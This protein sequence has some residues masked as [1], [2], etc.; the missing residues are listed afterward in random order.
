MKKDRKILIFLMFFIGITAIFLL[1]FD[2]ISKS[3]SEIFL[4]RDFCQWSNSFLPALQFF[5][6]DKKMNSFF[7]GDLIYF[8]RTLSLYKQN[9]IFSDLAIYKSGNK[10]IGL[11]NNPYP[12]ERLNIKDEI[13]FSENISTLFIIENGLFLNP[14]SILKPSF[15]SSVSI[16]NVYY[17]NEEEVAVAFRQN[18][19]NN[20]IPILIYAYSTY[21]SGRFAFTSNVYELEIFLDN[22]L[23]YERKLDN[24][25]KKKMVELISTS[26]RP[27]FIKYI[28]SNIS[29]GEHVLKVVVYDFFGRSK[30]IQKKFNV[31]TY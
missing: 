23:V 11:T 9:N 31:K 21:I 10:Y 20:F 14:L 19:K 4:V 17:L 24:I 29:D 13:E 1:F 7:S 18:Y 12:S 15:S 3:A 22:E 28:I 26:S 25:S 8:K 5:S 6:A 30:E 27:Q 2:F 16:I